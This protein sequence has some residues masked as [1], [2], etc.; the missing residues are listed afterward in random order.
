MKE[1]KFRFVLPFILTLVVLRTFLYF[2]PKTNLYVLGY[3]L[4]HLFTGAFLLVLTLPFLMLRFSEKIRRIATVL[5]GVFAALIIDEV[6]YLVAT[7][8]SDAAYLSGTSLYGM[9]VTAGI[10]IVVWILAERYAG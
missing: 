3:N 10:V 4:H 7:D 8:G 6:V 5:A 9:L 1:G 2:S